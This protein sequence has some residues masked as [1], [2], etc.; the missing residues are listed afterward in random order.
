MDSSVLENYPAPTL[1]RILIFELAAR[2]QGFGKSSHWIPRPTRRQ[3]W[4]HHL[5]RFVS[6]AG[7]PLKTH[8]CESAVD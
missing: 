7:A 4:E 6:P 5:V 1:M 3:L 8:D 2:L